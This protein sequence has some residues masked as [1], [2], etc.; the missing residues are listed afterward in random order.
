MGYVENYID[1]SGVNYEPSGALQ[2]AVGHVVEFIS[3]EYLETALAA[4]PP[5]EGGC[6]CNQCIQN[7]ETALDRMDFLFGRKRFAL[8]PNITKSKRRRF[9]D[10]KNVV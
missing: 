6:G 4:Q 7:H 2:Q 8:L 1:D 9:I 5:G 10:F 3:N